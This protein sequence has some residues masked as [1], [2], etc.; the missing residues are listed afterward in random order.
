MN[1]NTGKVNKPRLQVCKTYFE[2]KYSIDH[3]PVKIINNSHHYIMSI[4]SSCNGLKLT[5][6]EAYNVLWHTIPQNKVR[7]SIVK[8]C[9][10]LIKNNILYNVTHHCSVITYL[11]DIKTSQIN[12]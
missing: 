5:V 11:F 10:R 2:N 8:K 6:T 1:P 7:F 3:S 9:T 4:T 12:C